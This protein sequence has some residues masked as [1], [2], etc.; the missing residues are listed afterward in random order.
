MDVKITFFNETLEYKEINIQ[1]TKIFVLK[2][3]KIMVHKF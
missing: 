3:K 2:D 1:Q